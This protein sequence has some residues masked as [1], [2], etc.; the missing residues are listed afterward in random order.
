MK[1]ICK[2]LSRRRAASVGADALPAHATPGRVRFSHVAIRTH[3][4]ELWGGGGVPADDGPPLGLSW[5]IMDEQLVN[6][7]QFE[8]EREGERT[9]KDSYCMSG[10]VEPRRRAAMLMRCGSTLKQIRSVKQAVARLNRQR[11]QNSSM[12]FNGAW[13]FSAPANA[14]TTD[15]LS[16]LGQPDAELLELDMGRWNSVDDFF[17]AVARINPPECSVPSPVDVEAGFASPVCASP[18]TAVEAPEART[19]PEGWAEAWTE[20]WEE[21]PATFSGPPSADEVVRRGGPHGDKIDWEQLSLLL[22]SFL[23]RQSKQVVM[24]VRCTGAD[25]TR[26]LPSRLLGR[27]IGSV[28][29]AYLMAHAEDAPP[30]GAISVV[31]QGWSRPRIAADWSDDEPDEYRLEALV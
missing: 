15:T 29:Q 14:D 7:E 16:M 1:S 18:A 28:A 13:L 22:H 8:G 30:K 17:S 27:L 10:S 26:P 2:R 24:L 5:K 21:D 31:L 12:I 20:D 25:D 4:M 11:W 6:M 19:P 3:S 9:L 23:E